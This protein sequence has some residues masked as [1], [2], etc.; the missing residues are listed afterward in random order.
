MKELTSHCGNDNFCEKKLFGFQKT[1]ILCS[2]SLLSKSKKYLK[3]LAFGAAF[4]VVAGLPQIRVWF[5]DADGSCSER[6]DG[7]KSMTGLGITYKFILLVMKEYIYFSCLLLLLAQFSKFGHQP[8]WLSRFIHHWFFHRL[9]GTCR[10][11]NDIFD[12][13]CR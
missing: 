8:F 10:R 4:D 6:R 5:T 9:N 2:H 13:R 11:W 1:Q 7:L 3:L 12:D